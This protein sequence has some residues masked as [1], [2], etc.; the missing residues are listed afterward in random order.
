MRK[1]TDLVQQEI[2]KASSSKESSKWGLQEKGQKRRACFICDDENHLA[3]SCPKQKCY[4]C[5]GLGH[6]AFDCPMNYRNKKP[7]R[8]APKETDT[9]GKEKQTKRTGINFEHDIGLIDAGMYCSGVLQGLGINAL[10]DS[11]ATATTISNTVY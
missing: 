3:R 7:E 5:K 8:V 2:K 4:I 10:K 9:T 1:L 6:R 11:G